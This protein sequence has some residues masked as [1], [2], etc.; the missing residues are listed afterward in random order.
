MEV[1]QRNMKEDLEEV[2]RQDVEQNKLLAEH[3]AG[4]ETQAKRLDNEIKIR[5]ELQSRVASLEE[6]PKFRATLKQYLIGAGAI[7]GA[8]VGIIKLLKM[9]GML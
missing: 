8:I 2:K 9:S 7:A 4:V 3:I 6:A 1:E 5:E